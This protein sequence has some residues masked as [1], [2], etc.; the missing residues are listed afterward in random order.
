VDPTYQ[1]SEAEASPRVRSVFTEVRQRL[2]PEIATARY[3]AAKATYDRKE[4]KAAE[5]RS[6]RC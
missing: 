3:A 4:W 1:P 5:Q 6:V 2:L